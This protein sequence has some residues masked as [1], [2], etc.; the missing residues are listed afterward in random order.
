MPQEEK[1][2]QPIL[3]SPLASFTGKKVKFPYDF[4]E[5]IWD[6]AV[7]NSES[8]TTVAD[9]LEPERVITRGWKVK[10][11]DAAITLASSIDYAEAEGE[12]VGNTMTIPKGMIIQMRKVKV[13]YARSA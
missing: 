7:S 5:I 12:T 13:T 1:S 10:E 2:M 8:W 11:T 6:D 9:I 4:L 3:A